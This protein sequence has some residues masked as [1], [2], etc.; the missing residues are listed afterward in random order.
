MTQPPQTPPPF[1]REALALLFAR[2]TFRSFQKPRFMS[3]YWAPLLSVCTGARRNEIFFLT[4]EDVL[5]QDGIR[6]LRIRGRAATRNTAGSVSRD[7]PLHPLLL[8]LGFPEFVQDR[9]HTHAGERLFAEY[10]AIQEQAG[11]PF[12]RAFVQWIKTTVDRLPAEKKHLFADDFHFPS[13][14]A[15]FLLE[16]SRCG[17]DEAVLRR[18]LGTAAP[19]PQP[20]DDERRQNLHQAAAELAR[21]EIASFFPPL[22]TYDELMA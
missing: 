1:T 5:Q 10:R 14:R 13:L 12:S 16:A 21:M 17:M 20:G 11:V 8:T 3:H 15:L 6:C 7:I 22:L 18:M 9:Q 2:D 4:P 19:N